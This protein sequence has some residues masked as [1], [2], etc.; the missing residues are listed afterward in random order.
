[1]L[2]LMLVVPVSGCLNWGVEEPEA[3]GDADVDVDSDG[4]GDADVDGDVDADVDADEEEDAGT[5]PDADADNDVEDDDADAATDADVDGD[6][7]T[8]AEV[9]GPYDADLDIESDGD[10]SDSDIVIDA[11]PCER[12]DVPC[13]TDDSR[14]CATD[15]GTE[16]TETCSDVCEWSAVC[17]PPLEECN[18]F[19][20]DCDG[21]IDEPAGEPIGGAATITTGLETKPAVVWTGTE[22]GVVWR[23]Y[24]GDGQLY[25]TRISE[26]G[27][28]TGDDIRITSSVGGS[29]SQPSLVWADTGFGIAWETLRGGHTEINLTLVTEEGARI[30]D[31]VWVTDGDTSATY[32]SLVW[33]GSE[34]SVVWRD[35]RDGGSAIYFARFTDEG[36]RIGDDLRVNGDTSFAQSP[37]LAW[38]GVEYG[39]AWPDSRGGGAIYL[40]RVSAE[41]VKVGGDYRLTESTTNPSL[42]WAG[43]EFGLASIGGDDDFMGAFFTRVSATGRLEGEHLRVYS[44]ANSAQ[45]VWTGIEYG[46]VVD[47]AFDD[48]TEIPGVYFGRISRLGERIGEDVLVVGDSWECYPSIAWSGADYGISTS[49]STTWRDFTMYF[50]RVSGCS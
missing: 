27:V 45:L 6:I 5:T 43:T 46:V 23:N 11:G 17:V 9:D 1:M 3:D 20:D 37:S 16:G 41:G 26:F 35:F 36:V 18:G 48:E 14:T 2:I 29:S 25:F 49:C 22:Y 12:I 39:V 50:A 32:P 31:D 15:C 33:T 19:D 8:D 24:R 44:F 30:A 4:D 47:R 7:E 13:W 28:R 38:T 10:I 21:E 40:A 42:I 34:Y